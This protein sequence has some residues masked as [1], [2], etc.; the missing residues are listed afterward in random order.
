MNVLYVNSFPSEAFTIDCGGIFKSTEPLILVYIEQFSIL[1]PVEVYEYNDTA[2]MDD[3]QK[4]D[5]A[6][7]VSSL[8]NISR[9]SHSKP[10]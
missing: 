4:V 10:Q 5:L 8:R 7:P 6:R 1:D 2:L 3:D 9:N